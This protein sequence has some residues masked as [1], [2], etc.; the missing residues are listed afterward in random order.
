MVSMGYCWVRV[1]SVI[2]TGVT[3][4]A[5]TV[6]GPTALLVSSAPVTNPFLA[7]DGDPVPRGGFG[8]AT[9]AHRDG[10]R[11]IGRRVLLWLPPSA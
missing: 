6:N 7:A 2:V 10:L 11:T 5:R 9:H 4:F 1:A 3:W 8:S